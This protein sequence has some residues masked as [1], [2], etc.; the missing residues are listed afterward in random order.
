[1]KYWAVMGTA[2]LT[3]CLAA[4]ARAGQDPTAGELQ[5]RL[6]DVRWELHELTYSDVA[7]PQQ[8]E[9]KRLE[10]ASIE[11]GLRRLQSLPR[12]SAATMQGEA[13]PVA[14]LPAVPAV[15]LSAVTTMPSPVLALPAARQVAA[16]PAVAEPQ[17]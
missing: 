7:T 4:P 15:S 6:V 9:A 3:I 12:V 14:V 11:H 17:S 13:A 8:R 10:L 1:M 2:L 16:L 5:R